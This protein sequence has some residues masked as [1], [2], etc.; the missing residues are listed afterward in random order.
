MRRLVLISAQRSGTN[1]AQDLIARSPNI[2]ALRELFSPAGV[3]GFESSSPVP[4]AL[5]REE[6]GVEALAE[7]DASA[8]AFAHARPERLLAVAEEAAR[9]LDRDAISYTLFPD[10][11]S[12]GQCA[13]LLSHRHSTPVLLLRRP[14]ARHIS[15]AK[16]R[17]LGRW[18]GTDTTALKP[19]IDIDAFRADA[20][21]IQRWFTKAARWAGGPARVR[22]LRYENDL[23][24]SDPD[25]LERIRLA[26][27]WLA[28]ATGIA[29]GPREARRQDRT[30]DIFERAENAQ[31]LH[32]AFRREPATFDYP[33][34][35]SADPAGS[36]SKSG[37][38]A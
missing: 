38:Q 6:L 19:R 30:E 25:A 11:L 27:P 18:R 14:L 9:A 29:R 22:E 17:L 10:Q 33:S 13:A 37:A 31:A 23:A 21:A 26:V 34:W 12:D 4:M 1:R 7:R 3:F 24:I 5:L 2:L 16:A 36:I 15:A 8:V 32:A 20:L 28:P 35:R